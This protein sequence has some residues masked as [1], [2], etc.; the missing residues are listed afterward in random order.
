M[1]QP[2]LINYKDIDTSCMSQLPDGSWCPARPM[3]YQYSGTR[4]LKNRLKLSWG[5]FSGKYDAFDW[6]LENVK[7]HL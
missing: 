6:G 3:G 1:N 5:V 4:N 2:Q 7:M